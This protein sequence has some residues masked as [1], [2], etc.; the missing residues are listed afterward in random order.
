[1]LRVRHRPKGRR[2]RARRVRSRIA[3]IAVCDDRVA[4]LGRLRVRAS[5]AVRTRRVSE[6]G[7]SARSTWTR[8]PTCVIAHARPSTSPPTVVAAEGRDAA[9]SVS[10][11]TAP[12]PICTTVEAV[13]FCCATRLVRSARMGAR[14]GTV[15]RRCVLRPGA[16]SRATR[17]HGASR[18]AGW[19][20]A[21]TT[22]L[23][24]RG[25]DGRTWPVVGAQRPCTQEGKGR[26][27]AKCAHVD[28]A[29]SG[30]RSRLGL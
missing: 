14:T 3:R 16:A 2:R 30:L 19:L 9:R 15:A 11:S 8:A 27:G 13:S 1:M 28:A 22:H 17:Q 4:R 25:R 6:A 18:S 7:A 23:C 29:Y 21:R 26:G 10:R 12:P 24:A 20:T 5:Y